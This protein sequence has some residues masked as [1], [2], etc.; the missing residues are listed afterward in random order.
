MRIPPESLVSCPN[1]VSDDRL[2]PIIQQRFA[3]RAYNSLS[4]NRDTVI[5]YVSPTIRTLENEAELRGT[6]NGE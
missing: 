6:G 5:S 2:V 1:I 4:L 3:Q